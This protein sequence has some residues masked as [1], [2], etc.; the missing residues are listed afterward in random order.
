MVLA[1]GESENDVGAMTD[2]KKESTERGGSGKNPFPKLKHNNFMPFIFGATKLSRFMWRLSLYLVLTGTGAA[3]ATTSRKNSDTS[4]ANPNTRTAD[5]ECGP[6]Q[7]AAETIMEAHRIAS[8]K[9]QTAHGIAAQVTTAPLACFI[10]A[11]S[12]FSVRLSTKMYAMKK[13]PQR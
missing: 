10:H 1:G 5:S 11:N 3:A 2:Q 13:S 8:R 9:L 7:Q 6:D 4:V 12:F